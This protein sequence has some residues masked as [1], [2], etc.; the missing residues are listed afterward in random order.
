MKIVD[1][2]DFMKDVRRLR[3]RFKSLNEDLDVVK[4][5]LT[6]LPDERPPVSYKVVHPR[7]DAEIIN[8][9]ITCKSLKGMGV[10]S[11]LRLIY[12]LFKHDKR[13]VML[14]IFNRKDSPSFEDKILDRKF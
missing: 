12:A 6:V 9:A 13:I 7:A 3:K 11:G 10:C 4:R 14:G 2:G 8:T 1:H 5:V